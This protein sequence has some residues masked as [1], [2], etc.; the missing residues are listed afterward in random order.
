MIL[1]FKLWLSLNLSLVES[2]M[3]YLVTLRP[4][5]QMKPWFVFVKLFETLIPPQLLHTAL[6]LRACSQG[7]GRS[8]D[9]TVRQSTDG[10]GQT[11]SDRGVHHSPA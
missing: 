8:G 1:C 11:G 4:L 6:C 9:Q 10:L 5:K 7:S 3:H 2:T